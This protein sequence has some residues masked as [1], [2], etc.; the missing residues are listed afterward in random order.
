[1]IGRASNGLMRSGSK[2]ISHPGRGGAPSFLVLDRTGQDS[3]IIWYVTEGGHDRGGEITPLSPWGH[4]LLSFKPQTIPRSI[5]S[6]PAQ[7]KFAV[8]TY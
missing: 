7:T 4:R 5:N 6:S 1:M 3:Y 2:V 8:N